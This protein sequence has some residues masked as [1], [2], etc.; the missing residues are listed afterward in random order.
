MR[1][2]DLGRIASGPFRL[3][4]QKIGKGSITLV[5]LKNSQLHFLWDRRLQ[6]LHI[7]FANVIGNFRR[8]CLKIA[9]CLFFFIIHMVLSNTD[10]KVWGRVARMADKRAQSVQDRF[11]GAFR[12]WNPDEWFFNL[13]VTRSQGDK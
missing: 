4:M 2:V 1:R 9:V 3:R 6:Y 13:L 11:E 7:K 12:Q 8:G 10:K 5:P